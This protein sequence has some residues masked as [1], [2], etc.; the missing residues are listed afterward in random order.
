L[1]GRAWDRVGLYLVASC[2]GDPPVVLARPPR[3]LGLL[4]GVCTAV[5]LVPAPAPVAAS[6]GKTVGTLRLHRCHSGSAWWCGSLPRLLDPRDPGGAKIPIAFRWRPGLGR[7]PAILAAQGGPGLPSGGSHAQY[8]GVFGPLLRG[9]GLLLV[10]SRGTGGSAVIDCPAL[11]AFDG[12]SDNAAFPLRVAACARRVDA[13][14]AGR[15][16]RGVQP[17]NLFAT[18]YAADD[19]AA[20]VRALGLG[21][22]DLYGDSYGTFLAQSLMARHPDLLHA[23]ALDSAYPARGLDPWYASSGTAARRALDAVCAR[24]TACRAATAGLPSTPVGRL[25][26]LVARL[27]NG[28]LRGDVPRAGGGSV[29]VV[30]G[31]R[32]LVDVVQDAASDVIIDRELDA[33]VRAALAG[34]V[35]PLARMTVETEGRDHDVSPASEFS[36]GLYFAVACTDYPQLFSMRADPAQRAR[37]LQTRIAADRPVGA[38]APFSVREWLTMN[39]YSEAYTACLHWPRVR[40]VPAAVPTDA[41]P[42]PAGVPV[43]VLGGDLDSLTPV[44]D[45]AG[46]AHRLGRRVR[47]VTLRNTVHATI[48]GEDELTAGTA[49]G[50][51]IVRQF[52]TAPQRLAQLDVG[53]AAQLP[54]VHAVGAYPRLLADAA[55]A[56]RVAGPDPGIEARRAVTVAADALADVAT[57][58]VSASFR[59]GPG[60]GLRAG[61]FSAARGRRDVRLTLRGVRF[62]GDA[63]VSGRATYRVADGGVHG[64]LSVRVPGGA[65][66]PV[67]VDWTQQGAWATARVGAARFRLPAP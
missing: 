52:F 22:V 38:F 25:A 14:Y 43:L 3:R 10:D 59:D 49:C 5:A 41:A 44:A 55:P 54:G 7:G 20:V 15:V 33:S 51:G 60:L 61:R 45:A 40:D 47:V 27:R 4:L 2:A 31:V 19:T 18:A 39:A 26:Q 21:R 6:A 29:H 66:V 63:Q 9:R 34:D 11:Q 53:C 28:P 42:L 13:R 12:A 35:T 1:L 30:I 58:Q 62:V 67:V 24:S 8:Q 37:Q 64:A 32:T 50:Q 23:V 17:A 65:S 46:F 56:A 16:S 36:A 57:R 48:E